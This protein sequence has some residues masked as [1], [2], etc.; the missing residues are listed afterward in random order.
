LTQTPTTTRLP[1]TQPLLTTTS[2][3]TGHPTKTT[4]RHLPKMGTP[5]PVTAFTARETELLTIAFQCLK[6]K[7][8]VRIP[9]NPCTP[10][11][12]NLSLPHQIDYDLMAVKAN[13]KGAKSARDSFGPLYNK[14]LACKFGGGGDA[15]AASASP[16]KGSPLKRKGVVESGGVDDDGDD[17]EDEVASPLKKTRETATPRKTK[18]KAKG[19]GKGKDEVKADVDGEDDGGKLEEEDGDDMVVKVK[20]E[21]LDD[22]DGGGGEV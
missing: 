1:K 4:N 9:P 2:L 18:T 20:A 6:S 17:D 22:G 3:T 8:D 13:L 21:V 10:H 14:I 11:Q 19:K 7:P 12:P 5:K 15:T 16:A